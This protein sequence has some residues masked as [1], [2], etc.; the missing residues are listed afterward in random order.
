MIIFEL[1]SLQ[2]KTAGPTTF[3]IAYN[4]FKESQAFASLNKSKIGVIIICFINKENQKP[5]G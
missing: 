3:Y 2:P 1:S 4:N 5:R